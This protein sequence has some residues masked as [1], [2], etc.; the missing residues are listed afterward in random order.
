M[1]CEEMLP[2]KKR[3]H[4]THVC[5]F[6]KRRKVRCDKGT[7]CSA[8][9]KYGNPICEYPPETSPRTS[10][11]AEKNVFGESVLRLDSAP[12][13]RKRS[14]TN[15]SASSLSNGSAGP[16]NGMLAPGQEN[17]PPSMFSEL[18]YLKSKISMLEHS[19]SAQSVH[20]SPNETPPKAA[21]Q[22]VGPVWRTPGGSDDLSYML[23]HNPCLSDSQYF[24]FHNSYVPFI[25]VGSF[26]ARHYYPLSWVSLIKMYSSVAPLFALKQ[27]R[28]TKERQV[29]LNPDI[30]VTGPS[31]RV[32]NKKLRE[33]V[34]EDGEYRSATPIKDASRAERL[35]KINQRAKTVGLTVFEGD[36]DGVHDV[37]QK[38]VMLLPTRKV[39]WS[40]IDRFFERVYP[41]F[42]FLDQD[43]FELNVARLLESKSRA[44]EPVKHLQIMKKS[45]IVH[46]GILLLVL[47]L[48]YL[49][50]FTNDDTENEAN[51]YTQDPSPK[52]QQ[53]RFLMDNPIDVDVFGVA[54]ECLFQFGYMRFTSIPLLQL[55][56]FLKVYNSFAPENGEGA[57]DSHSQGF[58]S[59]IIDMAM[60]LGLH[61]EPENFRTKVRDDKTNNLCRK[62]WW[63]LVIMDVV[64]GLTNGSPL[65]IKRS[66]FDTLPPFYKL[67]NENIRD[68]TLEKEVILSISKFD[69]CYD[70]I[71]DV[72]SVISDV[73]APVPMRD[74]CTK[75]TAL[76]LQFPDIL[77]DI[78]RS[79]N[80]PNGAVPHIEVANAHTIKIGFQ[81]TFF[82]VSVNLHFF[83]H[84]EKMGE[85]DLAYYYLKKLLSVSV[86]NMMPFYDRF[87]ENSKEI[88][89]NTTDIAITPSFQT[90]VHK[91]TIIIHCVEM[92][93]RFSIIKCDMSP[94]HQHD[95]VRDPAYRKRYELLVETFRLCEICLEIFLNAMKRMMSRYYYC[96]RYLKAQEKLKCIRNG[97]EYYTVWCRGKESYMLLSD[98]MLEDLNGILMRSIQMAQRNNTEPD[99]VPDLSNAYPQ[100]PEIRSIGTPAGTF[101]TP[102][103][104]DQFSDDMWTQMLSMKPDLGKFGL[105]DS[106]P[107]A[108]IP[109]DFVN[110][111][112]NA[113]PSSIP[114]MDFAGAGFYDSLLNDILLQDVEF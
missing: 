23:G 54:Q 101:P 14:S 94:M 24:S 99:S 31:D 77:G 34:G 61:R 76:E 20:T 22:L 46:V 66:Q 89:K 64:A 78:I 45:Q 44:C 79:L 16:Q 29:L 91:C 33:F 32:F 105:E 36:L 102:N 71:Y 70:R 69:G 39:I 97:T 10:E 80:S 113:D 7:P 21:N 55:C 30:E 13:P 84:Y 27:K 92:R 28:Y 11:K 72:V 90:L 4:N 50:L 109:Q 112:P 3:S 114:N 53:R 83:N 25:T 56:L 104:N 110:L 58:C 48:S 35:R 98:E 38:A 95:L 6:C 60:S 42:P 52:A 73:R 87:V 57:D 37:L 63:Y 8:C 17:Y 1:L 75:L 85:L 59:R 12:R 19:M 74:F 51:L 81:A 18:E 111:T 96:W 86:F 47:R 106:P 15:S 65:A 88:F 41:F 100:D 82:M 93:A 40:L 2:A 103:I 62:I 68:T 9:V 67:G 26:S 49:T 108:S 5:N 43:E 107:D